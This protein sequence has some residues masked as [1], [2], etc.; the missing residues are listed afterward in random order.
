MIQV[1]VDSVRKGMR[2]G[3]GVRDASGHLLLGPGVILNEEYIARLKVRGYGAVWIEDQDTGDIPYEEN[4]SEATRIAATA[5]IKETFVMTA[6]DAQVLQSQSV[7][8]IRATLK[9]P[10][11][12]KIFQYHPVIEQLMSNVGHVVDEVLDRDIL[13]GLNSIR[14][15]DEYTYHHC[16]DMSVTS[17]MIGRHLGLSKEQLRKLA[18][19]SILHDIGKIFVDDAILNKQGPLT[20]EEFKRM[21]DHSVLGYILL[22]DNLRLGI[23]PPHIAYQ[24]HE[25][26]DGT[27]YPRGLKGLN[28][29]SRG[30]EMYA[31]G[32]LT[33]MGEIAA[34]A[35]FHDACCSD[36]RYR[37]GFPPDRVWQM[38]RERAGTH[39]NREI[40]EVFLSTL[41]IFPVGVQV[42]VISGRYKGYK[43]VVAHV[44]RDHLD[45]PLVRLLYDLRGK[46]IEPIELD[47]KKDDAE[48]RGI[49]REGAREPGNG[50]HD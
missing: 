21:K 11:F 14:S 41:P 45:R 31:P 44:D 27:G 1:A 37:K 18:I 25:R 16:L 39:F 12:Q 40:V 49:V 34:I 46:R 6:K 38:I 17:I 3:V 28:R 9:S 10:R 48:V 50:S 4:L 26:Q 36:R 8:E 19:G 43:G 35:D 13:T 29:I 33:L 5:A 24:H 42:I 20:P 22:K 23:L 47:L 32:R 2:L 15:H 7:S 30:R